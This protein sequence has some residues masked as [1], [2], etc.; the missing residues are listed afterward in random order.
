MRERFAR[1]LFA[2]I[3]VVADRFPLPWLYTVLVRVLPN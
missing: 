3:V 2:V 1:V